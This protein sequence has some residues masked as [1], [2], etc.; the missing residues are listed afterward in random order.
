M[1]ELIP[2]QGAGAFLTLSY[3]IASHWIVATRSSLDTI[4]DP[5]HT[6]NMVLNYPQIEGKSATHSMATAY[7]ATEGPMLVG[8]HDCEYAHCYNVFYEN[9]EHPVIGTVHKLSQ[10]PRGEWHLTINSTISK[11]EDYTDETA[12]EDSEKASD[13]T[14]IYGS[15]FY[16]DTDSS[17]E[18]SLGKDN[19]GAA[20]AQAIWDKA[21]TM[22]AFAN[23]GQV[24]P[25]I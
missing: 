16:W 20:I 18:N 1:V 9:Y 3:L 4:A 22:A 6:L 8:Y 10:K 17:D 15:Y 21:D 19:S 7:N 11:R 13:G 25:S 12:S 5:R 2:I 24:L 23:Q 14:V